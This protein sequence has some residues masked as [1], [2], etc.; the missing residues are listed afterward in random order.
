MDILTLVNRIGQSR[1]ENKRICFI[2][3][4]SVSV[5]GKN[6]RSIILHVVL[7]QKRDIDF[8]GFVVYLNVHLAHLLVNIHVLSRLLVID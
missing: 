6:Y 5:W 1:D 8:F 7:L 3:Y 4:E 2:Y